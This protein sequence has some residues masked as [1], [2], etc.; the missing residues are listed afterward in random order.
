MARRE[1]PLPRREA[2]RPTQLAKRQLQEAR[3]GQVLIYQIKQL[4]NNIEKSYP[5]DKKLLSQLLPLVRNKSL[6]FINRKMRRQSQL[7]R[8]R[9]RR[10]PQLPSLCHHLQWSW[11]ACLHPQLRPQQLPPSHF[12]WSLK[13]STQSWPQSKRRNNSL[14]TISISSLAERRMIRLQARSL[15]WFLMDKPSSI[16]YSFVRIKRHSIN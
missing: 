8:R 15:E 16:F 11:A 6:Q 2:R 14:A 10:L 13:R 5:R 12:W 9:A 7:L 4:Q 1:R 3:V